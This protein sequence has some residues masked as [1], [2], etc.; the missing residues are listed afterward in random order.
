M[1]SPGFLY[2]FTG[3]GMPSNLDVTYMRRYGEGEKEGG[4]SIIFGGVG[5]A[6]GYNIVRR[7]GLKDR[8]EVSGVIR[9]LR[10]VRNVVCIYGCKICC[11]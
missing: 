10:P 1:E 4:K 9:I 3:G 2:T 7:G 5:G 6:V 8:R 11:C